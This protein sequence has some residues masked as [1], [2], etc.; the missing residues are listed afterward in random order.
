MFAG[1]KLWRTPHAHVQ[2]CAKDMQY[3]YNLHHAC[4]SINKSA[5][6]LCAR[7][8]GA[9]LLGADWCSAQH[10]MSPPGHLRNRPNSDTISWS[11]EHRNSQLQEKEEHQDVEVKWS[12]SY[13]PSHLIKKCFLCPVT[14]VAHLKW[15]WECVYVT[16]VCLYDYWLDHIQ[17]IA[18]NNETPLSRPA[19]N[20]Q[21][22]AEVMLK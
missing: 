15:L 6:G 2:S 16:L 17:S 8:V 22:N 4:T 13:S 5:C 9:G 12:E 1:G 14:S 20:L 11:C 19:H 10:M 21:K 7:I 18:L 3:I